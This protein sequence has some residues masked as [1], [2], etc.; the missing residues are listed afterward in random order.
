MDW[1][2]TT[3][4]SLEGKAREDIAPLNTNDNME[5]LYKKTLCMENANKLAFMKYESFKS[6]Q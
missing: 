4:L 3:L 1:K 2:Y 6:Y 5:K